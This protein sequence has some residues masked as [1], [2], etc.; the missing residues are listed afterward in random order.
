MFYEYINTHSKKLL[1]CKVYF[2]TTP[3]VQRAHCPLYCPLG[4]LERER[5]QQMALQILAFVLPDLGLLAHALAR[6]HHECREMI[7]RAV[8]INSP[9]LLRSGCG[10][11]GT[12]P[13]RLSIAIGEQAALI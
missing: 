12:T 8:I 3:S 2:N 13:S 6:R 7:G 1:I 9:I 10:G 5:L 11:G 4:R